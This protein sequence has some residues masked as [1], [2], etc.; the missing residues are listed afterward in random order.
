MLPHVVLKLC[1]GPLHTL[2]GPGSSPKGFVVQRAK[3]CRDHV[4]GLGEQCPSTSQPEPQLVGPPVFCYL[5]CT[6]AV[7][8]Q[9]Q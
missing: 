7:E 5:V 2:C 3:K 4:T 6:V 1:A 8:N 9:S